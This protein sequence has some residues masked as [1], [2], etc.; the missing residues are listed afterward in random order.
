MY[1]TFSN[2]L[3]FWASTQD[4]WVFVGFGMGLNFVVVRFV[5]L[6]VL[7]GVTV[8]LAVLDGVTVGLWVQRGGVRLDQ[9]DCSGEE[10]GVVT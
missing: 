10:N 7:D 3:D 2:V 6:A 5:G 4:L 8:N 9:V 1:L